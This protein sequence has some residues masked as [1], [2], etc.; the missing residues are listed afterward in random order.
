MQIANLLH[1]KKQSYL[2]SQQLCA[3]S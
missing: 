3:A 1:I 2:W